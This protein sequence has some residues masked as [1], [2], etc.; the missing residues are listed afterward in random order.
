M[1]RSATFNIFFW[2]AV[3]IAV[4]ATGISLSMRGGRDLKVGLY[5]VDQV[6]HGKSPYD[7]I[8]DANRPLFRYAPGMTIIQYPFMLK[9]K[10][11]EPSPTEPLDFKGMLPSVFAWYL[12]ELI[13]VAL[14]GLM[15]LRLIPPRTKEE[16]MRNLKISLLLA[17]PFLLYEL[18]NSQN[19]LVALF[20][21]LTALLLFKEKRSFFSAVY[22]CLALTV[23]SPLLVFILYFMIKSRGRYIFSFIAGVFIVFFL[24]PSAVFGIGFNN[25]LLKEWFDRAI[26]PFSAA[27]SYAAYLDL[28]VSNQSL[29]G[30]IG[31]LL[32]PGGTTNFHY[33]ISP[34]SIHLVIRVLSVAIV[35]LSCFVVWKTTVWKSAVWRGPKDSRAGL[36]YPV[37]LMLAL[38]LPQYCIYYTWAWTFVFYFAALDY[39]G[40]ADLPPA[41]KRLLL[42]ASAILFIS[43]CLVFIPALKVISVISWSTLFL[44]AAMVKVSYEK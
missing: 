33:I 35:L 43:T 18:S 40:R 23:Y 7:N 41:G 26:K 32:A 3:S 20:F 38:L 28:R 37:F 8:S 15:L 13:A 22:F 39:A 1:K 29:P 17:F 36:A 11:V 42:T 34:E 21:L 19:K 2:T 12:A 27:G 10:I 30:A 4:I 24:V 44:W 6:L 9:S 16:G 14:S 25:F 31:R 5:G